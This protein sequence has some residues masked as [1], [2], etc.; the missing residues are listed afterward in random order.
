M[1]SSDIYNKLRRNFT[2]TAEEIKAERRKQAKEV[3]EA[4]LILLS[5]R[6]KKGVLEAKL[7][8]R[9]ETSE[10]KVRKPRKTRKKVDG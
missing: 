10:V 6:D 8:A 4:K 7:E 1:S 2:V 3:Q 9:E 5:K